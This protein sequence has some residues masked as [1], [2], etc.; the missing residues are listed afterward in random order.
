MIHQRLHVLLLGFLVFPLVTEL[1]YGQPAQR[2]PSR[3]GPGGREA[4][5][6]GRRGRK[7]NQNSLFT[8]E[9]TILT[10]Q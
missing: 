4:V 8:Q 9:K 3:G 7:R 6:A 2:G 10:L 5:T 1:T